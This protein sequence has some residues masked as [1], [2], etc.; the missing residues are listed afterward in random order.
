MRRLV[1]VGTLVVLLTAL[2]HTPVAASETPG[3]VLSI[4]LIGAHATRFEVD[5]R[6]YAGPVL[7]TA[8]A[9]G[10]AFT[11]SLPVE[12]YLFGI[13]EMPFL[14]HAE[15]LAAQ[16]VAARTYLA[17][18][19][20]G[21]RRGNEVRY[22]F[23]ICATVLCQV[24]RG[25]QNVESDAG[26]RWRAAVESTAGEVLLYSGRPIDAVYSSMMGSR[27]RA[28]Q[29]VWASSPVP[30]LQ[31]VDSP[32][33]GIAPF[34]EWVIEMTGDQFVAILRAD[35]YNVDGSLIAIHVDDP[36]EG[37]GRTTITVRSSGGTA[38]L[39]AGRVK[40]AFNR[41]GDSLFPGMLPVRIAGGRML[42][43]PMPSDT[44]AIFHDRV[45]PG[46]LDLLLPRGD[47]RSRDVVRIEGEGWGHGVGMSQWGARIMADRGATY[48]EILSHYYTGLLP[49]KAPSVV[50]Q[51]VVVG[52]AWGRSSIPIALTGPARLV[53]N[54][55][56]FA[57]VGEG[58]WVI[59]VTP[60]GLDLVPAGTT[61]GLSLIGERRWPR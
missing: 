53:V 30:Y 54:G 40:L 34:A 46:P 61:T 1:H 49:Q 29:D 48:A 3:E 45:D 16:A 56:A 12:H 27:T 18:S 15:A 19:L 35:G 10:I 41:S 13:A 25:I 2:T 11:E 55:L 42:P 39:F 33:I 44:F 8:R 38:S 51:N 43:Q 32:E 14:W 57:T 52:L 37:E 20:L 5:G 26:E 60:S 31:P 17:R 24:Y 58:E 23:D 59:R 47:R 50:P 6:R 4:E 22:G 21:G 7:F 28:N 36:P 9:D